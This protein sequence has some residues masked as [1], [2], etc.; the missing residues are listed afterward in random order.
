M[1]RYLATFAAA[2]FCLS[3]FTFSADMTLTLDDGKKAIL[4]DDNTWG[5]AQFSIT[6]GTEEDIYIT[7]ENGKTICLKT[8]GTWKYTKEQPKKRSIREIPAVFATGNATRQT[9]DIAVKAA[10]DEAVKRVAAQLVPY[11]TKSKT[12]QKYL[13]AC[14]QNEIGQNGAEVNYKP[15]WAAQAKVSLNAKQSK[16]VVECVETQL[17]QPA[18]S[19][20]DS[21]KASGDSAKA[22]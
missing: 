10:T 15:G 21:T 5:Y 1:V 3:S 4:H 13:V 16:N 9:L 20:Q 17:T 8:D 7:V 6:D 14:I 18:E 11:V 19:T 2:V 22:Q 12:T